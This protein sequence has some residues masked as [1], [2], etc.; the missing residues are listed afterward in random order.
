MIID[1]ILDRREGTPYCESAEARS[2]PGLWCL[3]DL[4]EY[5]QFFG[6][7]ELE[8]AIDCGSDADV[9]RELCRYI[10]DNGYNPEIKDFVN[11]VK[12]AE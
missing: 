12:W 7:A 5:A 1:V 8:R 3:R 9:K 11:S 6:F 10:D 4:Y 2:E